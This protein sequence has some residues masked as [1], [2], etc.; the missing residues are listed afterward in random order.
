MT[1]LPSVVLE[2]KGTTLPARSYTLVM[3]I[4]TNL[5]V[6]W[7]ELVTSRD[8]L[9]LFPI[10]NGSTVASEDICDG[11]LIIQSISNIYAM[12]SMPSKGICDGILVIQS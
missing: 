9:A 5:T 6:A 2:I 10:D 7:K 12:E 8:A 1:V 11:R 3:E 4:E